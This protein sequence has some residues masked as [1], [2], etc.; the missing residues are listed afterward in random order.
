MVEIQ[1]CGCYNAV[2]GLT[3]TIELKIEIQLSGTIILT[4]PSSLSEMTD[5]EQNVILA[6]I[7]AYDSIFPC[8]N[9][10][11]NCDGTDI[12]AATDRINFLHTLVENLTSFTQTFMEAYRRYT[13]RIDELDANCGIMNIASTTTT[14][15]TTTTT[16]ATTTTT[17]TATTATTATTV[18]TVTT[19]LPILTT[20]MTTIMTTAVSRIVFIYTIY[21]YVIAR[22]SKLIWLLFSGTSRKEGYA[23]HEVQKQPC[24]R[25]FQS[26]NDSITGEVSK[27]V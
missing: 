21:Y 5:L 6:L 1:L 16:A 9:P 15:A 26:I 18:T 4:T 2:Q 20:T 27:Y 7:E 14:K 11:K 19:A 23:L 8:C 12:T 22:K 3:V 10:T 24:L 17:T 25:Y 13:E